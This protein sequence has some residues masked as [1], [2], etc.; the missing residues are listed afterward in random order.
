MIYAVI[1]TNVIISAHI[2]RH[3]DSATRKI[4]KAVADGIVTP[5]ITPRS[6]RNILKS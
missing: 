6:L 1:D 4:I 2:T 3:D 5:V